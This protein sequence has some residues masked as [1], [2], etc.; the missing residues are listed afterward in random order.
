MKFEGELNRLRPRSSYRVIDA[1]NQCL[2][3]FLDEEACGEV[4]LNDWIR[5]LESDGA[6]PAEDP[7]NQKAL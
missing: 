5:E 1:L 7:V 3:T 2:W 6:L 4:L